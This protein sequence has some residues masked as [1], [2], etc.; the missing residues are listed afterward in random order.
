LC[1]LYHSLPL[2]EAPLPHS[3]RTIAFLDD[4]TVSLSYNLTTHVLFSLRTMSV[5]ELSIPPAASTSS[6]GTAGGI[7]TLGKGLGGYMTLGL[8]STKGKP[9]ATNVGESE[10]LVSKDSKLVFV[11]LK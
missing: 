7:S 5:T 4:E 11:C 9:C 1:A 10:V 8:G 2:Q 3:A 6:I